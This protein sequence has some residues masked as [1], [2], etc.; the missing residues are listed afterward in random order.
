[1]STQSAATIMWHEE[2]LRQKYNN[3]RMLVEV[4]DKMY[5]RGNYKV[6]ARFEFTAH[7]VL[8]AEA[9]LSPD[10]HEQMDSL[11]PAA[12]SAGNSVPSSMSAS[13]FS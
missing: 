11:S 8:W 4:L 9:D 6:K 3:P 13:A 1:M 7:R 5:G 12:T 10:Y 2:M